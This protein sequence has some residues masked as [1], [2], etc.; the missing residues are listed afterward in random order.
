VE[1]TA[2]T[3]VTIGGSTANADILADFST[4]GASSSGATLADS[5]TGS[6][7]STGLTDTVTHPIGIP[8]TLG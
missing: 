7:G 1:T 8:L 4:S 5:S 3:A 2:S 6:T